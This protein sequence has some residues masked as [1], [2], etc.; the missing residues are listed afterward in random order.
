MTSIF[1]FR[2]LHA[3]MLGAC[4]FACAGQVS[5]H[6]FC[7]ANSAQLRAALSA[8]SDGGAYANEDDTINIAGGTHHTD[9]QE[10]FYS[11][12]SAHVLNIIGTG[13]PN[14][15]FIAQKA[16][17]TILDGDDKSRVFETHS[18]RGA[19]LFQFLTIQNGHVGANESGGGLSMN[20]F[21]GDNGQPLVNLVI[22]RD[23]HAG[24]GGGFLIGNGGDYG[25]DFGN[26]LV[27][28]NSADFNAGAGEIINNGSNGT[29]TRIISNTFTK[30]TVGQSPASAVGGLYLHT[31]THDTLSNNIFWNNSGYDVKSD[32]AALVDNDYDTDFNAPAAGSSGNH[33]LDPQFVGPAN[34]R[35]AATSPLLGIGTLN[36]PGGYL[37]GI[38]IDAN[39]RV[40][41][42]K[43]DL[44]A[45]ER[46]GSTA[47][48][49]SMNGV[50]D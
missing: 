8:V 42:G 6:T 34:F 17:L 40:V 16:S 7:A 25:I 10:F 41:N 50:E 24:F 38:D 19:V 15:G 33:H 14:C 22:I 39:V 29:G 46:Q 47:S 37:S 12:T 5:A 23:N 18:T 49:A 21:T 3:A 45:F 30:N 20:A 26:N 2:P 11:S 1:T 35:L 28:R 13:T 31:V 43:I 32:I 4:A 44:G 36:P 27:V 48:A 9:G